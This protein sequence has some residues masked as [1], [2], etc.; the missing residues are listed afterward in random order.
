M[1]PL[2]MDLGVAYN[3]EIL[4]LLLGQA[5]IIHMAEIENGQNSV[6]CSS[7]WNSLSSGDS[8]VAAGEIFELVPWQARLFATAR[9]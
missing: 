6:C 3:Q 8:T 2:E 7:Q 9:I 5:M 4:M 1:F